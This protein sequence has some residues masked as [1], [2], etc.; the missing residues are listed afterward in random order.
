MNILVI[1]AGRVGSA[2]A[3]DLANDH[4][5]TCSD[6]STSALESLKSKQPSINTVQ[7]DAGNSNALT[8]AIAS[9]DIIVSAVPG[10]MGFETLKTIITAGKH[11]VDISF[12]PEDGLALDDLAKKQGV[13]AIIK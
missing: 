9:Y 8:E 1:G 11:V 3:I 10:F 6:L 5:V 4:N 13:T 12:F 2:M 7:V